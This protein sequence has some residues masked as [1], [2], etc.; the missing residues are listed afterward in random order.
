MVL[1]SNGVRAIPDFKKI[2]QMVQ[3]CSGRHTN[4]CRQSGDLTSNEI[5]LKIRGETGLKFSNSI[6]P[7]SLISELIF[8]DWNA[9][10]EHNPGQGIIKKN[11]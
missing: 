8:L 4:I 3:G 10:S 11:V 2:S 5:A 1:T 7:I 6:C 9:V